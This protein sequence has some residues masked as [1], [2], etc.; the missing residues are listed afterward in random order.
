MLWQPPAPATTFRRSWKTPGIWNVPTPRCR[1]RPAWKKHGAMRTNEPLIR[2]IPAIVRVSFS[3]YSPFSTL[4]SLPQ[5]GQVIVFVGWGAK[6][7]AGVTSK[8]SAIFSSV[9]NAGFCFPVAIPLIDGWEIPI[10][11][12]N[13]FSVMPFS[14]H[15]SLILSCIILIKHWFVMQI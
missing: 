10:F 14:L 13:W 3:Y 1:S 12:A 8:A 2:R 11:S 5:C 6:S 9:S 4:I 15:N 7:S